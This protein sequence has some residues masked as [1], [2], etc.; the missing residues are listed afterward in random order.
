MNRKES[1]QDNVPFLLGSLVGPVGRSVPGKCQEDQ[2][3]TIK[4]H[5]CFLSRE[6]DKKCWRFGGPKNV[7]PW[8]S[9]LPVVGAHVYREINNRMEVV[10]FEFLV[11]P[12]S[13]WTSEGDGSSVCRC[14]IM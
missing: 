14:H 10:V 2:T 13:L 12:S 3:A 8:C 4:R 11:L 9:S 1:P 5:S 6:R 7:P